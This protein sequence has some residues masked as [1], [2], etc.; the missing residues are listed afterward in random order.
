[1]T[2]EQ[3]RD[4]QSWGIILPLVIRLEGMWENV[5]NGCGIYYLS[6]GLGSTAFP[7]C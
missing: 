7:F 6:D 1:M 3:Q 2:S 4:V 5:P